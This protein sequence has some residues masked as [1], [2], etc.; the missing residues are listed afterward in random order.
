MIWAI[1]PALRWRSSSRSSC[2]SG[3]TGPGPGSR[4]RSPKPELSAA[5]ALTGQNRPAPPRPSPGAGCW[6]ADAADRRS[7]LASRSP[8]GSRQRGR[9]SEYAAEPNH[10][11][12]EPAVHSCQDRGTGRRRGG[13]GPPAVAGSIA[14]SCAAGKPRTEGWGHHR[15]VVIGTGGWHGAT[16]ELRRPIRQGHEKVEVVAIVC[17]CSAAAIRKGEAGR[18]QRGRQCDHRDLLKPNDIHGVVAPRALALPALD[19]RDA[20]QG[21]HCEKPMTLRLDEA[22]RPPTSSPIRVLLQVGTQMQLPKWKEA[23]ALASAIGKPTMSQ[24]PLLPQRPRAELL[25]H[26]PHQPRRQPRL[27]RLVWPMGRQP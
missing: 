8:P 6:Y 25:R 19:R 12:N 4:S 18:C 1:P 2:C 16:E 21:C 27:G 13:A 23:S 7:Q 5:L 11:V 9:L 3:R 26:R 14:A 20:R 17:D 24:R 15:M 22:L 10:V